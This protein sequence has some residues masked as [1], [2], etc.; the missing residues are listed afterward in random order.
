MFS[1]AAFADGLQV[2]V[3]NH[4]PMATLSS[5][6]DT[7]NAAIDYASDRDG[8]SITIDNRTVDLI[9]YSKFAW[10]DGREVT[11]SAPVQ[12]IDGVTYVPIHFLCDVYGFDYNWA[13]ETA[14][15]IVCTP[16]CTDG[17]IF[18]L[19]LSWGGCP[20]VWCRDFDCHVYSHYRVGTGIGIG[21]GAAP[22]YG[23]GDRYHGSDAYQGHGSYAGG[24]HTAYSQNPYGLNRSM[25]RST[26]SRSLGSTGS[27]TSGSSGSRAQGSSHGSRHSGHGAG[28]GSSHHD[29]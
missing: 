19:D 11:L 14:P 2:I 12:I 9:P 22:R 24:P 3:I 8:I 26:G 10:I 25:Q 17:F 7:F 21:H 18:A 4:Q 20:H 28:Q 5:F 6:G 23:G 13:N 1:V 15:V 16:W 27:R 29:K